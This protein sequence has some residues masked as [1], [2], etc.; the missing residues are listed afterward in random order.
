MPSLD[1]AK[2]FKNGSID[3]LFIDGD[4]SY[5]AVKADLKAWY[6]KVKKGGVMCGHDYP[7]LG[8]QKAINEFTKEHGL[9]ANHASKSCWRINV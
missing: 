4:H 7:Q 5:K 2:K 8:V 6:P 3:F 1:A 9:E